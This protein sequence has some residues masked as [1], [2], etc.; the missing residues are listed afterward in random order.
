MRTSIDFILQD[1]ERYNDAR[2]E[3]CGKRHWPLFNGY[4]SM[5]YEC[6]NE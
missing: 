1:I 3:F 6:W 2:L 5:I 4:L